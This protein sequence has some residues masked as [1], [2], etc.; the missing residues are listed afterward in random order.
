METVENQ[1]AAHQRIASQLVDDVHSRLTSLGH[2]VESFFQCGAV[3]IHQRLHQIF[4][5][6][7]YRGIGDGF[8]FLNQSA[9]TPHVVAKISVI[10][11]G[12]PCKSKLCHPEQSSHEVEGPLQ[13]PRCGSP[14]EDT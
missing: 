9:Y 4:R 6:R 5:G 7:P 8:N 12:A 2:N 3:E 11:H 14:K 10:S 13:A 1:Y